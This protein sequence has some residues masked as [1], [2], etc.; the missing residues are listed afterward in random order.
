MTA[1]HF[2]PRSP[3]GE[4]PPT[5]KPR[6]RRRRFQPT[7][8]ARGATRGSS[9]VCCVHQISTHAPRTGSDADHTRG[10]SPSPDFNP[11]SPHGERPKCERASDATRNI[12]THAPRTGSDLVGQRF[13]RLTVL[14]STHAPRTGSDGFGWLP[15]SAHQA[16][17]THAPRT[18]SDRIRSLTALPCHRTFQP[19]LPARGATSGKE[20][21]QE[22][23]LFQ[24]T[25][26]ARGATRRRNILYGA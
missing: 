12:S 5:S 7:L 6:L 15:S 20:K 23:L 16:I 24:P 22:S 19:T 8:P 21:T 2:N 18:G 14:I 3:H 25:L 13:G 9:P 4:R 11:R 1:P 26:P 17:S 10:A